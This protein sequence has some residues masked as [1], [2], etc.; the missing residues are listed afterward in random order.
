[1]KSIK[2]DIPSLIGFV[3]TA[4]IAAISGG[5]V[6]PSATTA[7]TLLGSA[8]GGISA[9]LAASFLTGFT[10]SKIKKWFVDVHPD[11]LN[12]DIKKLFIQSVNEALDNIFVLFSETQASADE[13]KQAKQLI[14]TLQKHLPDIFLNN[15]QILLEEP[16]IKQFLYE[17]DKEEIFCSFIENQFDALGITEPFKSFLAK[18]LPAQIQLCF[19][20]GL[21]Q[22]AN[23]NAWIAFQRMLIEE[24]RNDIKQIAD[25]Q[26]SIKDDLSD[27]KFEKSG[28]SEK[29]ITE[30]RELIKILNN[31]KLVEVKI[32]SALDQSI[33]S[34]EEK[35]DEIIS[36]T[37]DTN[38]TV[39]RI[40][41]K[42]DKH[43][44][45]M[46]I[47]V[48][49]F[50]VLLLAVCS[51]VVYN[52][53]YS[54]F[55][56]TIQIVDWKGGTDNL[57]I[58]DNCK[59]KLIIDE[60]G[61]EKGGYEINSDYEVVI[62]DVS[63]KYKN[64]EVK[65]KF[66]DSYMYLK[67]TVIMLKKGEKSKSKIYLSGLDSIRGNIKDYDNGESIDSALIIVNGQRV[68]SDS[69]GNFE[70]SFQPEKQEIIQFIEIYKTNYNQWNLEV[71]MRTNLYRPIPVKLH[72]L[73]NITK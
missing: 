70:M 3:A 12:H 6:N 49:V 1:M 53:I 61:F 18:H 22:P 63:A 21:K 39:Q 37:T 27:L 5:L 41:K 32:K 17:K 35:V 50:A 73:S 65:V 15:N 16:E 42:G 57:Y 54:P 10:P 24:I 2:K 48:A 23:N 69:L 44:Q 59:S 29:Q 55:T 14:K 26:Q 40:E 8:G 30:I 34:I 36:T 38:R 25:T 58:L 60:I 43:R 4:S 19:G 67:D 66:Q 45:R 20:E 31:K 33:K 72:R 62:P 52:V 47:V 51:F 11:N 46:Y 13:K 68:Y 64:K 9:S 7:I 28:F 56:A 71:D